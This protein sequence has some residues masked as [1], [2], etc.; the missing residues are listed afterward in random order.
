[1]FGGGIK[2]RNT[3]EH[4]THDQEWLRAANPT[5]VESMQARELLDSKL[6]GKAI[7]RTKREREDAEK[8]Y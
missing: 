1:M 4:Y 3:M 6:L 2:L 7:E 5:Y 8:A